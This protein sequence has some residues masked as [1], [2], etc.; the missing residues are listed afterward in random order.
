[1]NGVGE[2]TVVREATPGILGVVKNATYVVAIVTLLFMVLWFVGG[3]KLR[4]TE[5]YQAYMTAK[6]NHKASK[7]A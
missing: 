4:K 5:A 1:M 7:K 3:R 2:D 6:K